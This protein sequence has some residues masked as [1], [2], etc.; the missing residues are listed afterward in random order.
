MVKNNYILQYISKFQNV[1]L[2]YLYSYIWILN[3]NIR[4]LDWGFGYF[5]LKL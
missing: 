4:I 2:E 1:K 5:E 3:K